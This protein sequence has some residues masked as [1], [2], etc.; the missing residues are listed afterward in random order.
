MTNAIISQNCLRV[1]VITYYSYSIVFHFF[2]RLWQKSGPDT[3]LPHTSWDLTLPALNKY[4]CLLAVHRRGSQISWLTN[5]T[6]ELK[7]SPPICI[8]FVKL[9]CLDNRFHFYEHRLPFMQLGMCY[10]PSRGQ[11]LLECN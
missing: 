4:L 6:K 3:S 2:V 1:H 8:P 9:T 5:P 7:S 11:L 10:A